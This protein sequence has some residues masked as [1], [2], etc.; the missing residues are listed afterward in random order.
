LQSRLYEYYN[1]EVSATAK[2]IQME[3]DGSGR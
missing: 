2:P 1:P 3:V